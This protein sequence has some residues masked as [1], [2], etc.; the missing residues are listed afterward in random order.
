MAH[1]DNL[2]TVLTTISVKLEP[3]HEVTRAKFIIRIIRYLSDWHIKY[4]LYFLV[5]FGENRTVLWYIFGD[6]PLVEPEVALKYFFS[7]FFNDPFRPNHP[8][9]F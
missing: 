5:A 9:P 1:S 4:F 8:H 3:V 7:L 6:A 2:S